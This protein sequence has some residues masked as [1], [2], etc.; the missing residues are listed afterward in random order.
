MSEQTLSAADLELRLAR[1]TDLPRL[2][3][4]LADDELGRTREDLS[5]AADHRYE[6]AFELI[7]NDERNELWTAWQGDDLVGTYQVTY[8]PYLS[9][10]GNERCLIEAVR[11]ASSLRGEGIGTRMME[12]ALELARE[13]GCLLAQLTSDKRRPAAHRFYERLGFVASHEGMKLDLTSLPR[14]ADDSSAD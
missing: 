14:S 5:D 13:R 11:V 6:R 1:R 7:L 8:I 3:E 2:R 9:R 4:L 12:F 10:G